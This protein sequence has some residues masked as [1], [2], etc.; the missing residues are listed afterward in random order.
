[1]KNALHLWKQSYKVIIYL[2]N[3]LNVYCI[4][5]SNLSFQIFNIVILLFSIIQ[6]KNN[7]WV[8]SA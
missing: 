6:K 8:L 3:N 2:M 7:F 4:L 5:F 1:M